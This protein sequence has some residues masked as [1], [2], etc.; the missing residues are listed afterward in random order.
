MFTAAEQELADIGKG[1]D[2][3]WYKLW[4]AARGPTTVAERQDLVP[5]V[6]ARRAAAGEKIK[7]ERARFADHPLR[8][9]LDLAPARGAAFI[10]EH[11]NL[12]LRENPSAS[13]E[14]AWWKAVG[15]G[16][17]E[18]SSYTK[19][20]VEAAAK[21]GRRADSS[22]RLPLTHTRAAPFGAKTSSWS[23]R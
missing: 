17:Q 21:L 18:G 2:P 8:R 20:A 15:L 1:G 13:I 12:A 10:R 14:L 4:T 5:D 6:V 11:L 9:L 7:A 3:G 23:Q 22:R 16:R 19:A